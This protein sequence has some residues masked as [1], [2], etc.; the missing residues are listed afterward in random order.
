MTANSRPGVHR[1]TLVTRIVALI[2]AGAMATAC[3]PDATSESG[4]QSQREVRGDTTLVTTLGGSVWSSVELV[5]ELRIGALDGP[6]E[7]IFGFVNALTPDGAGGV[8]VFDGQAP[9][10]RH[11]DATGQYLRTLGGDGAGPGEYRDAVLGLAVRSD[12]R[13]VMRDARNNRL[14]VYA[15]DGSPSDHW[16]V[17][18]GLFTSNA[19]LVDSADHMYL[20]ILLEPP[21]RNKPWNIGLLHL[22]P[23]GT[24]VDSISPPEIAGEPTD[25]GSPLVPRKHW[26]R[27][28]FGF[29]VVGISRDYQFEIRHPDG[30]VT[31]VARQH[32]PVALLPEERAERE[33]LNE[34]M[35]TYR[36]Q[37]LT[38]LPGSVPATKPAYSAIL[39]GNDGRIWVR[40][41]VTA[42]KM[43]EATEGTPEQPPSTSWGEPAVYDVFERDGTYLGEV[44]LPDRTSISWIDGEHLWA[45]QRGDLDEAYVVRYRLTTT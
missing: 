12:G 9:A 2:A 17:E 39:A 35:R 22:D 21:Q 26:A 5:E 14:N 42:L 16:R 3:A 36:A 30:R 23:T 1:A 43:S 27:S 45:V 11:Y 41:H 10:L 32:T 6:E 33:E 20:K 18:S 7:Y 38:T 34:W 15:P 40:R 4:W 28:P 29:T 24:I 25:D 31:R 44:R 37:T 8:Y 19:L 13:L